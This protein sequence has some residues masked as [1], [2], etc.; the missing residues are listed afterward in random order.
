[1]ETPNAGVSMAF[2]DLTQLG[3]VEMGPPAANEIWTLGARGSG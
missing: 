3:P 1:M 2:D